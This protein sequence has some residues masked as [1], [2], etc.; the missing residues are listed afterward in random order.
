MKQWTV[1]I[2][3]GDE[4]TEDTDE[5]SVRAG[6]SALAVLKAVSQWMDDVCSKWPNCA[7]QRISVTSDETGRF[8]D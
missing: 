5:I 3:W 4:S 6:S 8:P 1:Y 7:I 2:D